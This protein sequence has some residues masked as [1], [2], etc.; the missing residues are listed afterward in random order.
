[1]SSEGSNVILRRRAPGLKPQALRAFARRLSTEIGRGREFACLVTGDAE[2]RRLNRDFRRQDRPTDVL[3]F[4][5]DSDRHMG[6]VAI[7]AARARAQARR[8]GHSVDEE[9]K[10]L[11]L[12]GVLHLT[13]LDH[14][15][16]DGRMARAEARWRRRF[17]LSAG[18]TE[19]AK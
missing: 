18:L 16:D 19:R 2:I 14:E 8:F 15:S 1:M 17:G 12:H 13:G 4:P 11:M 7:S 3:S 6:D 10:I 9:I 5:S